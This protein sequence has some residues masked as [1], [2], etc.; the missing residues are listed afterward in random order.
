MI[1]SKNKA[2]TTAKVIGV[3]GA[4]GGVGATTISINLAAALAQRQQIK[5][6]L[7]SM[8]IFNNP[9]PPVS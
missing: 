5:L 2:K 9:M 3:L 7:C 6:F 4:K 8:L 1:L